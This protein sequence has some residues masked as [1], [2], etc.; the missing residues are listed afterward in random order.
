MPTCAGS[1]CRRC[2]PTRWCTATR[3]RTS[4]PAR[5]LSPN[6]PIRRR[7]R[8]ERRGS[9]Q[10]QCMA[11]VEQGRAVMDGYEA[12]VADRVAQMSTPPVR[13]P[14]FSLVL[15]TVNRSAELGVFID[16]LLKQTDR[17]FELIVVDQNADDR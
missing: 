10:D 1:T 15:A 9:P 7:S 4:K 3:R 5:P 2:S 12:P 8:N 11:F 13:K 17:D 6:P 14:K 16:S